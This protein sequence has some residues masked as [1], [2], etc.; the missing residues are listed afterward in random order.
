MGDIAAGQESGGAA[1]MELA[2]EASLER[3]GR[4]VPCG[5][6]AAPVLGQYCGQCGQPVDT[7]RRSVLHLLHDLLKDIASF[8]S[9][10]LRTLRAIFLQPGELTTAFREGR[11]Q[12]YVPPIRLYLILAMKRFYRQG[13]GW[14]IAKFLSGLALAAMAVSTPSRKPTAQSKLSK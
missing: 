3:G 11:V 5:N 8:D 1:A 6:C 4:I 12:R 14:T 7:H 2:V 9:R 13:W 10:V